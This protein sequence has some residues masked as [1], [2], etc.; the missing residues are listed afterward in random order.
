MYIRERMEILHKNGII[1]DDVKSIVDKAIDWL[2]NKG[3]NLE[4]ERGHMFLTHFAMSLGRLNKGEDIEPLPE[5]MMAEIK[6]SKGYRLALEFTK[7][8]EEI[9][10]KKLPE[11]EKGYILLHLSTLK[12]EDGKND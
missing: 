12:E 3:I 8:L 4:S 6:H 9:I 5:A 1:S 11:G 2:G 10:N 7:Y